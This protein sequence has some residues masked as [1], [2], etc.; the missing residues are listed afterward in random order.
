MIICC[1]CQKEGKITYKGIDYCWVHFD[2]VSNPK[3]ESKAYTQE[4]LDEMYNEAIK[5]GIIF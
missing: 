1:N 5:H 3:E 4:E 2:E